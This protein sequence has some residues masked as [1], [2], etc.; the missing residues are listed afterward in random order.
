MEEE[1]EVEETAEGLGLVG[2]ARKWERRM[3]REGA[4]RGKQEMAGTNT[5][6]GSRFYILVAPL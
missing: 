1:E 4:E 6:N 3:K 5:E 2:S